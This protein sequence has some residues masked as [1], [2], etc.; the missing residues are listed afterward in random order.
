MKKPKLRLAVGWEYRPG[1]KYVCVG[2]K[3]FAYGLTM[4]QS[5]ANWLRGIDNGKEV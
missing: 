1:Y 5:Y 4:D 2:L 3:V